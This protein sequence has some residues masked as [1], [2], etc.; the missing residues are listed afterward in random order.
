MPFFSKAK[1]LRLAQ[2]IAWKPVTPTIIP[3][4]AIF[5]CKPLFPACC[6]SASAM[7]R[8]VAA[9]SCPAAQIDPAP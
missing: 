3:S 6:S 2:S 9:R 8:I 7:K 1:A 4:G 5:A